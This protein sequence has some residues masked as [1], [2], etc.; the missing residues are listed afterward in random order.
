[1][2]DKFSPQ[3]WH[4]QAAARGNRLTKADIEQLSGVSLAT[5]WNA[6]G[7]VVRF[8]NQ[9]AST[10]AV[11]GFSNSGLLLA[12]QAPAGATIDVGDPDYPRWNYFTSPVGYVAPGANAPYEPE[13]SP[14]YTPPPTVSGSIPPGPTSTIDPDAPTT[15]PV[16]PN[17]TVLPPTTATGGSG[18]SGSVIPQ[19]SPADTTPTTATPVATAPNNNMMIFAAVAAIVVLY[20]L[21]E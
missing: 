2:A 19:L 9:P 17:I 18:S 13:L 6:D 7:S 15:I 14:V 11:P 16:N 5:V 3:W 20:L 8:W 4:D 10:S 1:M 21:A 12:G